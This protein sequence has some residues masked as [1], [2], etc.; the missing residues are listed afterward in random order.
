MKLAAL[1]PPADAQ[2]LHHKLLHVYDLEAGLAHETTLLA[3][4]LPAAAAAVQ[5]LPAAQK[6][7]RSQLKAGS[8]AAGQARALTQYSTTLG[9]VAARL[10]AL[11]P[12]PLLVAS[13]DGQVKRLS[14]ARSLAI[15]LRDATRAGDA[16]R[17]AR[18]LLRFR[19]LGASGGAGSGIPGGALRTYSGRL[20]AIVAAE[21]DVGR[22]QHRLQQ[23]VG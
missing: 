19:R 14:R 11:H 6:R 5:P 23:R 16:Q 3:D 18:I 17:I 8:G 21:G 9:S 15:Q 22:E 12:P 13:R 1:R 2:P 20:R 10:R 4:Y 7:L